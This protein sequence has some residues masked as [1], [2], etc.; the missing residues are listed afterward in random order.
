[1]AQGVPMNYGTCQGGPWNNKQ[2]AHPEAAYR[3]VII[4]GR[5]IA[6]A[7]GDPIPLALKPAEPARI[8]YYRFSDEGRWIWH[9]PPPAAASSPA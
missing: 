3:V 7:Q 5:A 8:G 2:L 6:G 1:M 4:G 9:S